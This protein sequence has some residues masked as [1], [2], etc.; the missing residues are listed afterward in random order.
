KTFN[1]K[2][3][4]SN[5]SDKSFKKVEDGSERVSEISGKIKKNWKESLKRF[6]SNPVYAISTVIFIAVVIMALIFKYTSSYSDNASIVN[7]KVV[8]IDHIRDLKSSSKSVLR[9]VSKHEV[10]ILNNYHIHFSII[11][12]TPAGAVIRY[13]PWDYVNLANKMTN[14]GA[15]TLTSVLGTDSMGHDYWTIIWSG[16]LN[17]LWL[18]IVIAFV[19]T[20]IGMTIGSFIGMHPGTLIDIFFMKILAVYNSIPSIIWFALILVLFPPGFMALFVVLIITGWTR[21]LGVA[22][23]YMW[24]YIN[25]DFMVAADT[26]GV[27]KIKR[28][29]KHALPNYLGIIAYTFVGAIPSI[30]EYTATLAF[31]GFK[32]ND[33]P[34]DLGNILNGLVRQS[35]NLQDNI[36]IILTPT[37]IIFTITISLHFVA[38]G[39]NDALDPRYGGNK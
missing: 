18:A 6:F 37:F 31:L 21:G 4:L 25:S 32:L 15:K 8:T 17:S 27:S 13:N 11:K 38:I 5:I 30:I 29:F 36:W 34:A 10:D 22:R 14:P 16:T 24:K 7:T 28:I 35:S 12:N 26:M 33:S 23:M 9:T 19:T 20:F 3:K 39:V 1:Q 2:Y